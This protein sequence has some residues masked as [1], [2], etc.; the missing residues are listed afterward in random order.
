MNESQET[1][2]N[3][4]DALTPKHQNDM[5]QAGLQI[6]IAQNAQRRFDD[7][8]FENMLE[9]EEAMRE[10]LGPNGNGD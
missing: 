7:Q 1:I 10:D 8:Q 4:Y 2:L 6:L 5:L 3:L 9:M